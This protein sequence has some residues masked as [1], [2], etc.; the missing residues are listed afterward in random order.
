[1]KQNKYWKLGYEAGKHKVSKQENPYK[2]SP[3]I[4]K[5]L[6][7]RTYWEMG[8]DDAAYAPSK[9]RLREEAERQKKN[10]AHKH[11]HKHKHKH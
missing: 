7:K 10:H 6:R 5:L 9:K 8:H 3:D 1:M 11:K 4:L 2:L